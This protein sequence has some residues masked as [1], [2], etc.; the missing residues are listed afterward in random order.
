MLLTTSMLAGFNMHVNIVG[1]G[2]ASDV[3]LFLCVHSLL[4]FGTALNFWAPTAQ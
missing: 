2:V 4:K 3:V 1:I